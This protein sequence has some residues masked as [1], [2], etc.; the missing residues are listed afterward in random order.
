MLHL[1]AVYQTHS[2]LVFV[3][4]KNKWLTGGPSI[5][6]LK[7]ISPVTGGTI[8]NYSP[9][10]SLTGMTGIFPPNVLAG[11]KEVSGTEGPPTEKPNVNQP[12][13]AG[14]TASSA[15]FGIPFASQTGQIFYAPMQKRPGTKITAQTISPAYSTSSVTLATTILPPPVQTTT[16]T[17]SLTLSTDSHAHT[18]RIRIIHTQLSDNG[19]NSIPGYPSCATKRRHAKVFGTLERLKTTLKSIQKLPYIHPRRLG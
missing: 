1:V 16:F 13:P 7:I 5:S 15:S 12:G 8:T 4:G 14:A 3:E 10:F 9:R 17:V 6:F 2:K 19:L 11:I 18:V